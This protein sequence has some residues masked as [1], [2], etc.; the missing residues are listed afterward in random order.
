V[1]R[2]LRRSETLF[3]AACRNRTDDL[4]ITSG[5]QDRIGHVGKRRLRLRTLGSGTGF[6]FGGPPGGHVPQSAPSRP[7]PLQGSAGAAGVVVRE[8]PVGPDSSFAA[9]GGSWGLVGQPTEMT[10]GPEQCPITT[11]VVV[12]GTDTEVEVGFFVEGGD[13]VLCSTDAGVPLL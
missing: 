5:R 13:P 11:I 8:V 1:A 9:A 7:Q 6:R 4:F 2:R 10:L 12:A 3:R